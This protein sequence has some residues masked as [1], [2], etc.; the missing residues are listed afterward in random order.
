[1]SRS[2]GNYFNRQRETSL[3]KPS[4]NQVRIFGVKLTNILVGKYFKTLFQNLDIVIEFE[5]F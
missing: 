5:A 1:M 3:S 2:E 4:R